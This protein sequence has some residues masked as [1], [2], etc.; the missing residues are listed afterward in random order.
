GDLPGV[1]R[2]AERSSRRLAPGEPGS[3]VRVRTGLGRLG[4]DPRGPAGRIGDRPMS[5]GVQR[6]R[7]EPDAIR[8]GATDKGEDPALVDR[9]LEVDAE[10]RRLLAET[11]SLKADR[12]AAS[13]RIGE[14]IQG[15]A[16]PDGPEVAEL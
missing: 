2:S 14:A 11:E 4:L 1:P 15:G 10:R 16:A 9:A 8:R 5:V 3:S 7:D 13:K 12:N 6:I